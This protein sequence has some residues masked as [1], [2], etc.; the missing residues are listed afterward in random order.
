MMIASLT[1]SS[2][3]RRNLFIYKGGLMKKYVTNINEGIYLKESVIHCQNR[4][5]DLNNL[6]EIDINK[7]ITTFLGFGSAVTES[8]S[9]N[10]SKL[11][12]ENKKKFLKDYYSKDGLNYQFGRIPVGSNDFSLKAF[13]YANKKDLSDFSIE[14]DYRYVIP[15]LKDI[16]SLKKISLIASPWSPP[17]MYKRLPI[18][19]FGIKLLKKYYDSYSNYLIKFLE[20]YR[21]I[22]INIDYLTIQ[23]EPMARQRWESCVFSLQEQKEFIYDSL[24][25]KLKRTKLLLWDHN[26]DNLSEVVNCLYQ[27]SSKIAGICFHY[28]TGHEFKEINKIRKEYPNLLLINS[29]M[30]CSYSSYDEMKWVSSAE[31]Y[32]RDTIGDMNS[33]V[34]AYLDW[35]ILLDDKGGPT[36]AKNY[37]KSASVL[38]GSDYIKSPIYYYLYH[39]SHFLSSN[40]KIVFSNSYTN[41]L[42][43]VSLIDNNELIV[44]IMNDTNEI[45][46]FNLIFKNK[47]I[48]DSI[49]S[50]SIITYKA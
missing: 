13:S 31:Y 50:H 29:E 45:I 47:Y 7:K 8:S 41:K 32:L 23:N 12:D 34:N 25:P 33:G 48:S 1:I 11:T 42:K 4:L 28:Y 17:K 21:N 5:P 35:N 46:D 40:T 36:H 24:L 22:G 9:Y 16:L 19:Y 3:D 20:A 6:I 2:M 44:V 26:K 43:V 38:M 27:K 15:F 18:F 37:V 14:H 30:C 10:Y 39:I 49:S